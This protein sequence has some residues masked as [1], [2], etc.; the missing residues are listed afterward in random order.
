MEDALLTGML[1][2]SLQNHADRVKIAVP[3]QTVNVIAPIMTEKNGGA[4]RQTTFYPFALAARHGRGTALRCVVDSPAFDARAVPIYDEIR[5]PYRNL[6]YLYA[7]AVHNAEKGEVVIFAANRS[8][9]E[10]MELETR[11]EDFEPVSVIEHKTLHHRDLQAV[12]SENKEEVFPVDQPGAVLRNGTLTAE[13][14]PASWNVLRVR[15]R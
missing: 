15:L 9:D 7:S 1:I 2:S 14:P 10:S 12:N 3:A 5:E 8:T 13:L 11:L 4:W 6:P